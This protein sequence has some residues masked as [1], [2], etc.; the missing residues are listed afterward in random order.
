M[1]YKRRVLVRMISREAKVATK[2]F[3][4]TENSSAQSYQENNLIEWNHTEL[5]SEI[6]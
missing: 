2:K 6:T 5:L 4:K 1:H 3:V